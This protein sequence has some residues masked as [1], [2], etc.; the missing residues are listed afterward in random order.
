MMRLTLIVMAFLWSGAL[1]AEDSDANLA[2][3]YGQL[4]VNYSGYTPV[5]NAGLPLFAF[6]LTGMMSKRLALVTGY[7][8]AH[9]PKAKRNQLQAG[10]GNIRLFPQYIGIITD[11]ESDGAR[12][13]F[14][15]R[16]T[17]FVEAGVSMGKTL[18]TAFDVGGGLEANSDFTGVQLGSGLSVAIYR[19][20][21]VQLLLTYETISGS[22]PF[23]V[24]GSNTMMQ[25]GLQY[26]F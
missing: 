10:Y 5:K 25:F 26:Q 7:R 12:F 18:L 6:E 17:Y 22:G 23:Q 9:S 19:G 21:Y 20:Y 4:S 14:A 15:P 8:Q 2:V 3:R 16:F 13:Q 24:S 1:F 11:Q